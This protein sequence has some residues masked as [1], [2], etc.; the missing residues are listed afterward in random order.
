VPVDES[1][2]RVA[3]NEARFREINETLQRGLSQ[4]PQDPRPV[5]FICEC[6]MRTC[7]ATVPVTG[8]E[9]EAVRAHPRRFVIVPGHEFPEAET[10]VDLNERFAVVEKH[11]D[12]A[13]IVES[14]HP[15][16]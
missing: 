8:E 7:E 2:V 13:D 4:L 10:V 11:E 12:V 1:K 16:A 15:R 3:N 5:A 6:G 9:Y 14:T